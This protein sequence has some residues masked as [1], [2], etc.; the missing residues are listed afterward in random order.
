[1]HTRLLTSIL[2]AS[3][4]RAGSYTNARAG[5]A[6]PEHKTELLFLKIM[7]TIRSVTDGADGAERKLF[8]GGTFQI[9]NAL[10]GEAHGSGASAHAV[11]ALEFINC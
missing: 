7:E 4:L 2:T 5:I 1:M 10:R 8:R 6:R 9:H 11:E 3:G